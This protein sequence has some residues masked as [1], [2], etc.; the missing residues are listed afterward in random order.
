[1]D[2]V[3][4]SNLRKTGIN[5]N[6]VMPKQQSFASNPAVQ[7]QPETKEL[8]TNPAHLPVKTPIS[9]SNTGTLTLPYDT[10]VHTYKLSNGQRVIIIPKE[11]ETVVKTYVN[12]GAMNEPDKVRGISHYIEHNLFNGSEGLE[13]GD[14]FKVVNGM[15]AN[16]NAST[17]FSVTDYFIKSHL[18]N[19]G[20]LEQ[21]IK[22]HASML[23]TP[24]FKQEKLD[25]EKG[26]VN[27]EIN[28]ITSNAS[29]LAFNKTLKNLYNINSTSSDMIGGT[30]DNITNLTR[31]D[32]VD[33]YNKNYYPANMVTV[34]TG[35]IEPD[36]TIKLISKHFKSNRKPPQAKVHEN[37]KPITKTIREDI[38]SDKTPATTI[39]MAF[40]GPPNNSE[41][42]EVL[43]D[44]LENILAGS[45]SSRLDRKLKQFNTSAWMTEERISNKPTD[46]KAIIIASD[47]S[48]E[49]SEKVLKVMFNEIARLQDEPPTDEE[50]QIMKKQLL[51]GFSGI[52]ES[53]HGINF[54]IGTALL[55]GK[56]ERIGE[57]EKTINSLTADDIVKFAKKYLDLNKTAV[58]VMHPKSADI[59]SIKA[60]HKAAISFSRKKQAINM[61]KVTEYQLPNN[62]LLVTNDISTRN[63]YMSVEFECKDQFMTK[64]AAYL[65][66]DK[67][68]NEGS[69][70]K[71]EEEFTTT[72]QKD[73]IS[74]YFNSGSQTINAYSNFD[75]DDAG[76]AMKLFKEVLYNPRFEQDAFEHAKNDIRENIMMS[77][78]SADVNLDW[79]LYKG[80]VRGYTN[81]EILESLDHVTMEDLKELHSNILNNAQARVVIS[82]PFSKQPELFNT[83]I[84]ELGSMKAVREHEPISLEKYKEI[85]ETKVISEADNK[86]QANIIQAYQF[87]TNGNL[88]DYITLQLMNSIL[89]SGTSSRLFNDLREE[90]KLAYRVRSSVALG[91][92]VGRI[93]LSIGTTTENSETGEISYDNVQKS[94][95]GF[96]NHINKMINE[97]VS[98]E[99][100]RNAKLGLKNA[101][102]SVCE[103]AGGKT[104]ALMA[105]LSSSYGTSRE[106]QKLEIVDQITAEDIQNA[107]KHIF[108]GKPIY[109]VVATKNTLKYN[110]EYLNALKK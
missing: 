28:M 95:E 40:N 48:D 24:F 29:G 78:K 103:D 2:I 64:P 53:S 51:K 61:K 4:K 97:K 22:I 104:D 85:K 49:N 10:K 52:F 98:D 92:S 102:L 26:I 67:M 76:K 77:E 81:D 45:R 65:I 7:T 57:Y 110:E 47:S 80:M 69:A 62:V 105:G 56:L 46:G 20:D 14:F 99:E 74:Q 18:L 107:A 36:E 71:T 75:I 35:E 101:L 54:A 37:L 16:T 82:A 19:D 84:A 79:E 43:L 83:A 68:L 94:L 33:Y 25:K 88:K 21:K 32:V 63:S 11:G 93:K 87:E 39:V 58:T 3:I 41:K 70:F 73:G 31:E 17:S 6:N 8:Q 86:N 5:L 109:S 72:R 106:N 30:T 89:G 55:D 108:S 15:G 100:L 27:S 34:I 91:D 42:E 66:L 59:E 60:N 13:E 12:C 96:K 1:M 90:Q 9:Y 44:A 38:I 50:M 23:E